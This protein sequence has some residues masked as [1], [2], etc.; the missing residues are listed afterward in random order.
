MKYYDII[1]PLGQYC[2]TPTAL[3]RLKMR[4]KSM[5][6]DWSGCALEEQGGKGGL[7]VKVDLICNNFENFFNLEDLYS[8]GC[9]ELLDT[10]NLWII[11]K[12]TGLQYRHDFPA[13]KPIEESYPTVKEKLMKRVKRL[14]DEINFSDRICFLFLARDD[15]F[16]DEYLIRQHQ[17]LSE[18]FKGKHIDLFFLGHKNG[19]EIN[20]Y[21]RKNINEHIYRIDCN[22]TYTTAPNPEEQWNGNTEVYYKILKEELFVPALLSNNVQQYQKDIASLRNEIS[23]L[24]NDISFLQNETYIMRSQLNKIMADRNLNFLQKI[25]SVKNEDLHKVIRLLGLKIKFRRKINNEN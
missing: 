11:N 22:F 1:I 21:Y 8:N 25:F 7:E 6:F 18:K 5:I 17:K 19:L 4:N 14:Y 16:S 3:D 12:R 13:N 10:W 15:G 20:E 2:I 23:S 9:N 24:R